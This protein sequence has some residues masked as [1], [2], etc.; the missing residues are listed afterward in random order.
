MH[1][2]DFVQ[3]SEGG[4]GWERLLSSLPRDPASIF[5]IVLLISTIGLVV[6]FGRKKG[7]GESGE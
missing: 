4:L 7:G 6:W 3:E 5:V 2:V 1:I